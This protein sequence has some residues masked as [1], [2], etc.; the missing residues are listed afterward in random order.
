MT[1][2]KD[3][4]TDDI[5]HGN[6]LRGMDDDYI[7]KTKFIC[8]YVECQIKA[9]PCSFTIKN[10]KQSYFKYREPHKLR[11]GIHDER[12]KNKDK[13]NVGK[14]KNSPPSP[15]VSL[16]RLKA[17]EA[18]NLGKKELRHKKDNDDEVIREHPV[19]SSFIKPVID[20]YL[21]GLNNNEYLSIP[22]YEK[23]TYN[24]YFQKINYKENVR[25]I[26]PAIYFGPLQSTTRLKI[27]SCEY[28]IT[29]LARKSKAE[30]FKLKIDVS[31]WN[32]SQ[33]SVFLTEY[34]KYRKKAEEHRESLYDEETKS[35]K[36]SNMFL[37]VFFFGFPDEDNYFLFHTNY[38]KLIYITFTE[39]I[40]GGFNISNE[41][42]IND[43]SQPEIYDWYDQY[44]VVSDFNIDNDIDFE[45]VDSTSSLPE[46]EPE[47]SKSN[48]GF[49]KSLKAIIDK[50]RS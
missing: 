20:Y 44:E 24:N 34:E 17:Y 11:C 43:F 50:F 22:P 49:F 7:K 10:R 48:R 47:E 36:K 14:D 37:T 27:N 39:E 3:C 31:S 41:A 9:F 15:R 28:E 12:L 5:V 29:F 1:I 42:M 23:R 40:S 2:A 13:S 19:S 35:Y 16:L 18:S 38:F 46:P 8:P 6:D 4:S 30:A 33:K 32:E 25:Y 26:K 21:S 45:L